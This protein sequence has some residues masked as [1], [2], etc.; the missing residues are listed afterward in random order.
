MTSLSSTSVG[1]L[2]ADGHRLPAGD[3]LHLPDGRSYRVGLDPSVP[4]G[5]RLLE[6]VPVSAEEV[7]Y[8]DGLVEVRLEDGGVLWGGE[9]DH[10][11]QGFAAR[12]TASG[13]LVWA[14][15]LEESNPFTRVAVEGPQAVFRS[16]SG[17]VVRLGVEGP[18]P[19]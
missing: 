5:F 16:T 12:L 8:I 17:V 11:S 3:A 15:F 18:G 10:G 14:L 4:A 2:W 6:R 9:G 13:A 1:E 19:A 7:A